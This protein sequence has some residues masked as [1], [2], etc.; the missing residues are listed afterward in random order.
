MN[1]SNLVFWLAV[2]IETLP[3][4]TLLMS[5]EGEHPIYIPGLGFEAAMCSDAGILSGA[6]EEFDHCGRWIDAD[7][8]VAEWTKSL[9][10]NNAFLNLATYINLVPE[11]VAVTLANAFNS[12][13][14]SHDPANGVRRHVLD[15]VDG[16]WVIDGVYPPRSDDDLATLTYHYRVDDNAP[17]LT[18]PKEA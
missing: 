17:M 18:T 3:T 10:F 1:K 5:D 9:E 13:Y 8:K 16:H 14:S 6:R 7:N 11:H 2:P 12:A 15:K 4:M